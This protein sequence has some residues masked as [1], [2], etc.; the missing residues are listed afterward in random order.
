[1][2]RPIQFKLSALFVLV[3]VV[4]LPLGGIAYL[5]HKA[6]DFNR[7][8]AP[9]EKLTGRRI[10]ASG[11]GMAVVYGRRGLTQ[12]NLIDAD[13]DDAKL[14]AIQSDLESL[15]ELRWL[16]LART[17]VGDEGLAALCNL[18]RQVGPA[19]S[20]AVAKIGPRLRCRRLHAHCD[21]VPGRFVMSAQCALRLALYLAVPRHWLEDTHASR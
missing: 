9:F 11:D 1:M 2:S 16:S 6:A 3:L 5:R 13:L 18:H 14:L 10:Q 20:L 21:C 4:S 12:I 8:A 17:T 7:A 15:P 19:G